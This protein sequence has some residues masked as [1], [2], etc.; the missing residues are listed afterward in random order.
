[1]TR[2]PIC[3][4]EDAWPPRRSGIFDN[5]N[6]DD[7]IVVN[8]KKEPVGLLGPAGLYA[9]AQIDVNR[10][11][12]IVEETAIIPLTGITLM[13]ALLAVCSQRRKIAPIGPPGPGST[14]VFVMTSS[15]APAVIACSRIAG[16]L[17]DHHQSE[18]T[19]RCCRAG[20]GL[21][22]VPSSNGILWS[23]TIKSAPPCLIQLEA[24]QPVR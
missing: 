1:M 3:I 22:S 12:A 14:C 19:R 15:V 5:H 18:W 24:L 10:R 4:R 21:I 11:R 23:S 6:I 13:C 2:N 20:R 7:L 9:E 8:V 16:K 17:G